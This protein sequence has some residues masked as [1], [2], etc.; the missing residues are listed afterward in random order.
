M[1]EKK[2][3]QT[4]ERWGKTRVESDWKDNQRVEEEKKQAKEIRLSKEL[5]K[6]IRE[7]YWATNKLVVI[8]WKRKESGET[9]KEKE[10]GVKRRGRD[11]DT[12]EKKKTERNWEK[13]MR[14]T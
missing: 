6:E 12:K 13:E 2:R 10:K 11:K 8:N 7:Q 5:V 14:K 3:K 1:K 9:E 4:A